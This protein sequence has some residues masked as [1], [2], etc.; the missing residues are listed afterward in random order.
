MHIR[1]N[2]WELGGDWADPILWY[3]RGVAAMKA[4]PI[5]EPTSWRSYGAIH[6]FVPKLWEQ[7]GYFK[8]AEK[9]PDAAAMKRYWKQCQHGSWYFLPWH[10]GYLLAFE[11]NIRAEVVKLGG[12][13]DWALPY[14]NYFKPHQFQ[15]PPA[16]A[17][18]NWPDGHG[19]NPLFVP[20]RYGPKNDGNVYVPL[21]QVNL[22]AMSDPDFTGVASGGSPGFGGVDTGFEHGGPTHGGL[23]TQPHDWVHGLV[24]GSDPKNPKLPG[25]M[26]D[27]DTAGLDPIFYLHHS[28]IDRL[29]QVWRENPPSHVDPTDAQW[30]KGPASIGERIFSMPMPGDK[31]WDYTPA[32]MQDPGKLGYKYED[33]KPAAAP[34]TIT[35]R[36]HKLGASTAAAEAGKGRPAVATGNKAELV[37]ANQASLPVQG[38]DV[39]T[40]VKLDAGVR[41]KVSASLAAASESAPPDRVFLNLENVRGLVDSTAFHVYVGLAPGANPAD[42]PELLAGSVALFGVRKASVRDEEHAGHGLNFVLEITHI[43]DALHL[44]HA[45][46][47]DSLDVRLVPVHPVPAE[48][49]VT[50]GRVSIYRQGR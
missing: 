19:N 10:R 46:D 13:S 16:F 40:S 42:H 49:E 48:A 2:V 50:I 36:L 24:G 44:G 14:W 27:P 41:R 15:L 28:N 11:A 23:E 30:L 6:G 1:K 22:N 34:T 17:S 31:P 47:V 4:H 20:Q 38:G 21:D 43:V 45:L 37:G 5:A 26:S 3:A 7:L 33:L 9:L 8:A 39:H 35:Q 29:W 32:E 25:L 12:P 18:P